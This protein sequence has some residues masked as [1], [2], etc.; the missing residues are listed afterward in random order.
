MSVTS[1]QDGLSIHHVGSQG[2]ELDG[3]CSYSLSYPSPPPPPHTAILTL[4]P[5]L[6]PLFYCM[7]DLFVFAKLALNS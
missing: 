4:Y 3:K 7:V 6:H 1:A 5:F 2:L